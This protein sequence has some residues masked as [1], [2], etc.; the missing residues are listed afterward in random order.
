ML[1][2]RFMTVLAAWIRSMPPRGG[3][4]RSF[5]ELG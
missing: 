3:M 5:V 2:R 1:R 4:A